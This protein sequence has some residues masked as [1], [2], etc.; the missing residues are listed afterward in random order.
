MFHKIWN[1]WLCDPGNNTFVHVLMPIASVSTEMLMKN[2]SLEN[3]KITLLSWWNDQ[4]HV[5]VDHKNWI[6]WTE[7]VRPKMYMLNFI[8]AKYHSQWGNSHEYAN[9]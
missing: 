9:Q 2:D 3:C 6:N 1:D 5:S 4:N 8:H 7:N